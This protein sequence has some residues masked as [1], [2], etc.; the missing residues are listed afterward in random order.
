MPG[1]HEGQKSFNLELKLWMAVNHGCSELNPGLVQEQ[2]VLLAAEPSLQPS[3]TRMIILFCGSCNNVVFNVG[4]FCNHYW[5]QRA[6]C[7][8]CDSIYFS[9][10]IDILWLE[11][12]TCLSQGFY[13]CTIIMTKKQAGE[14]RVYSAYTFHSAVHHQRKSG[15][16]LKQVRKQELMQRPWRDVLYWLASPGLLSLLSYRTQDY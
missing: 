8:K 13:S 14:E 11:I 9:D 16:E 2:H 12:I 10:C 3:L 6:F 5:E 15:L 4:T 7:G 1:I